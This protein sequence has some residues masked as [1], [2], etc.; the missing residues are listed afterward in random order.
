MDRIKNEW[1]ATFLLVKNIIGFFFQVITLESDDDVDQSAS[2]S[3]NAVPQSRQGPSCTVQ[4]VK[5]S[6]V[7]TPSA[8]RRRRL[9]VSININLPSQSRARLSHR[10]GRRFRYTPE[11]DSSSDNESPD[12]KRPSKKKLKKKPKSVTRVKDKTLKDASKGSPQR[13]ESALNNSSNSSKEELPL[14]LPLKKRRQR[15]VVLN[16]SSDDEPSVLQ[17]DAEPDLLAL[18]EPDVPETEN[19]PRL[20]SVVVKPEM[21][22]ETQNVDVFP[23]TS[24]QECPDFEAERKYSVKKSYTLDSDSSDNSWRSSNTQLSKHSNYSSSNSSRKNK[25]KRVKSLK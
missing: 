13:E 19:K 11:I 25:R 15:L 6:L 22:M 5:E 2:T 21:K 23:S 8:P 3:T 18:V 7:A 9:N 24:S 20:K 4:P 1:L 10:R 16:T 14:V 17:I 12:R